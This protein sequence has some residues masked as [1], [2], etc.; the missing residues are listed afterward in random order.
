MLG[1]WLERNPWNLTPNPLEEKE[2]LHAMSKM[3]V[4]CDEVG[5]LNQKNN[6]FASVCSCLFC[7]IIA[8]CTCPSCF[9]FGKVEVRE[10]F[11]S[12]DM[13]EIG[14]NR[15]RPLLQGMYFIG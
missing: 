6:F 4:I 13:E 8:L 10:K 12:S 14:I 1:N 5:N 11:I 3:S 15:L 2:I 7:S 9:D